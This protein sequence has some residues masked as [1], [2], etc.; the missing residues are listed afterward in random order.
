MYFSF[1]MSQSTSVQ[2]QVGSQPL[3]NQLNDCQFPVSFPIPLSCPYCLN[4]EVEI[5]TWGSYKTTTGEIRRFRCKNCCRT[6]N[7]SKIPFWWKRTRE[8]I[9]KITQMIIKDRVSVNTLVKLFKVPETTLRT[10]VIAIKEFLASNLEQIKQLQERLEVPSTKETSSLR[11]IFYDEGF[12]K[13]L[14][15]NG[16]IMFTVDSH[17]TPINVAIEPRRDAET[18][19]GYFV[20]SMTQLGGIDVIVGDGAKAILSA[21]KALRQEVIVVQQI[22][23]GKGKRARIT[24]LEP[25]HGKKGI[26][27]TTIEIHTSS[28]L[29]NVESEITT[30]RK[31]IYP[32]KWATPVTKSKPRKKKNKKNNSSPKRTGLL[33]PIEG[34]G[35]IGKHRQRKAS[36]LKGHKIFLKTFNN[37]QEFELNFI[38]EKSRVDSSDCPNLLKIHSILS[39]VQKTFPNQF[40]TSNRAEV[41]NALHDRYN[42]Y[43]GHKSLD[44]ANRDIRAW[45]A[46][47][48]FPKGSRALLNSHKWHLP[49]RLFFQLWPLMISR[50]QI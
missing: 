28:I 31:K 37:L 4:E 30:I 10:L 23:Q 36:L 11:T 26:W 35:S 38:P 24:Q 12:L 20:Q 32:H 42:T 40:I 25:I 21:A 29:C 19:H 47:T 22:H 6:F 45:T 44:H 13:L 2:I 17:G 34:A 39:V 8:I 43:L 18:I 33:T 14:G 48:F 46:I 1:T 41:F 7:P 3:K 5:G 50:V 9:W 16:F 49:N 27:A 15:V